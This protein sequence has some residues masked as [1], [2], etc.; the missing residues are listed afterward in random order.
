MNKTYKLRIYPNKKQEE[1]IMKTIGCSR[2]IY[3]YFLNYRINMYS[4]HGKSSS[5]IE[6][7]NICTKLKKEEAYLWLREADKFALNNS[8][9]DLDMAYKNFFNKN[10]NFPKFKTKNKSKLSYRTNFTRNNICIC[11]NKLKLPKVKWL[12]FRDKRD[13]SKIIKIIN[14]TIIKTRSGKYYACICV[15][16][17]VVKKQS[18]GNIIGIDLGLK[19]FLITSDGDFVKNPR[20]L[21]TSEV[22]LKKAH[23]SFSKKKNNSNNK[24]KA[25]IKFVKQSEKITNQRMY[26]TNKLSTKLINENQV[27]VIEGLLIENMLKNKRL[28]KSISDAGWGL[29]L[30]QLNSKATWYDRNVVRIGTF[31]PSSQLCSNCGNKSNQT[32]NL[33][34]REYKCNKCGLLIDRDLNASINIREEGIRILKER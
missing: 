21:R 13:L 27:I 29:F 16:E 7:N 9:R 15:E 5:Y 22:K 31:F 1:I 19:E 4:E 8:L 26:F 17:D 28:S 30:Q 33:G 12:K 14:T 34:C 25:R 20:F 10:S 6:T 23:S 3:N 11:D 18:T 2:F 24:E 32:K